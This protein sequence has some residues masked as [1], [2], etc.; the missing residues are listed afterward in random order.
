MQRNLEISLA[1]R[2]GDGVVEGLDVVVLGGEGIGGP[3]GHEGIDAGL[4]FRGGGIEP[5]EEDQEVTAEDVVGDLGEDGIAT[6][7]EIDGT[8]VVGLTVEI[9]QE[10]CDQQFCQGIGLTSG[11]AFPGGVFGTK[12][13]DDVLTHGVGIV[14]EL[15]VVLDVVVVGRVTQFIPAPHAE[16]G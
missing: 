12:F 4:E 11:K 1:D 3:G 13:F 5:E 9:G 6:T 10:G 7:E 2:G 15:I 14:E 8:A 16:S